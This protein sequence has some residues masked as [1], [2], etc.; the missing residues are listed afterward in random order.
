MN[1]LRLIKTEI[2]EN[3]WLI[4]INEFKDIKYYDIWIN[5]YKGIQE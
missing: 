4:E 1:Y 3:K 5:K 2:F